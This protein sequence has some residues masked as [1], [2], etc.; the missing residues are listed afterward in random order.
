M[1]TA[2]IGLFPLLSQFKIGGWSNKVQ[3]NI[4]EIHFFVK[5]LSYTQ[6]VKYIYTYIKFH[7]LNL[8][9]KTKFQDFGKFIAKNEFHRLRLLTVNANCKLRD[10]SNSYNHQ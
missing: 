8:N 9:Q 4:F 1:S 6:I 2:F 3:V 10:W 5:N 7:I